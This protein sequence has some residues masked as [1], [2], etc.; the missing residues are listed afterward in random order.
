MLSPSRSAEQ[1]T[2][3]AERLG[4]DVRPEMESVTGRTWHFH[5]QEPDQLSSEDVHRPADFLDTAALRMVEGPFDLILVITDVG[6]ASRRQRVVAGLASEISRVA[7][8]S[9]LRLLLTPR[10]KAVRTLSDESVRWN[11]A[12]LALHLIG[13]LL[14]LEHVQGE[15]DAM[16]PFHFEEDQRELRRFNPRSY[17]R[18]RARTADIPDRSLRASGWFASLGFHLSSALG[19]LGLVLRPLWRNRAI[20]LPL[21]L[22]SLATAAVVPTFI[23]VFTAEI[24]DVGLNLPPTVA[25]TFAI[26]SILAATAYLLFVQNLFFPHKEKR[27][28]TEHLAALNVTILL[29]V[30]LAMFGL[31]LMVALLMLFVETY[32]FPPGLIASWPTLEDPEVTML[33]KI[34]IAAFISSNGVLTGALAGG[35]ESRAVIR[36]LALFEDEV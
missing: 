32:I 18:L 23:L 5:L 9:T 19:N 7:I 4:R 6:L 36:N 3:F 11:A 16:T 14:G 34:I 24:W 10:G 17:A 21:S 33:D 1:M 35:M 15:A 30:L 12:T 20:L 31:F 29:S 13:H 28:L 22:P 25:V 26:G 2:A 27:V 8:L